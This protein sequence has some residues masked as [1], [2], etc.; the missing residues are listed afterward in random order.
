MDLLRVRRQNTCP[1]CSDFKYDHVLLCRACHKS[2]EMNSDTG[3]Y[4]LWTEV[5]LAC[6]ELALSQR[7]NYVAP[8]GHGL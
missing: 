4:D 3:R 2:H 6:F 7:R 5:T 8:H 1:T